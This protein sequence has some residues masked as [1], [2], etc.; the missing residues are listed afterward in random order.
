MT[1][2]FLVTCLLFSGLK[3]PQP[4][5]FIK[6]LPRSWVELALIDGNYV[7]LI[8][9]EEYYDP[10]DDVMGGFI[11]STKSEFMTEEEKPNDEYFIAFEEGFRIWL[12]SATKVKGEEN[13][14]V[15]SSRHGSPIEYTWIVKGKLA[16]WL[17]IDE[18]YEGYYVVSDFLGEYDEYEEECD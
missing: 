2:F 14:F 1:P 7:N 3:A 17:F 4:N 11:I 13:R 12:K 18:E 15:I 8:P 10:E 6:N 5:D 9:C 16:F